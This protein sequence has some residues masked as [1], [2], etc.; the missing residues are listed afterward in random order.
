MEIFLMRV[1]SEL[2]AGDRQLLL[3]GVAIPRLVVAPHLQVARRLV[4]GSL[5]GGAP[6]LILARLGNG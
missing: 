6:G 5:A 1:P 4:V 2:V 3:G